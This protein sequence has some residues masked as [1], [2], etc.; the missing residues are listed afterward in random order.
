MFLYVPRVDGVG[1]GVTV[2]TFQ[3]EPHH[4]VWDAGEAAFDAVHADV[5]TA[6]VGGLLLVDDFVLAVD[7]ALIKDLGEDGQGVPQ[8]YDEAAKWY[9]TVALNY[10]TI[11][12]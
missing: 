6:V 11:Q 2:E 1:S 7:G 3:I 8:D 10:L 4:K 9:R 5:P 12:Y